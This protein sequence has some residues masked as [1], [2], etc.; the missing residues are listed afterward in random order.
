MRH[1]A[2]NTLCTSL[3]SHISAFLDKTFR[4]H[5]L[6]KLGLELLRNVFI[7]NFALAGVRAASVKVVGK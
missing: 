5:R 6:F 7:N 3:H 2:C 4:L 1:F